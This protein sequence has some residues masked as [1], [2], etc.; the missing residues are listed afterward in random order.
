MVDGLKKIGGQK[1]VY[2]QDDALLPNMDSVTLETMTI[3]T[4]VTNLTY[5]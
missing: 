3:A 5:K 4:E 1:E 2:F